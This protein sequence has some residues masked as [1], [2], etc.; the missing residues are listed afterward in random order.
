MHAC[1]LA[2]TLGIPRVLV[3][4]SPGVLSALG[5][6]IADVVKDYSHTVMLGPEALDWNQLEKVF[7]PLEEQGY[8]EMRREGFDDHSMIARRFLDLRY[9]GQSYEL[10]VP[11]DWEKG[12][13]S[14]ETL[15]HRFHEAHLQRYGHSDPRKPIELVNA[16]LKMIGRA[17]PVKLR[18]E[19]EVTDTISSTATLERREVFF[20]GQM[21]QTQVYLREGL[22]PGNELPGPAIVEQLDATTVI[23]PE[24]A[25]KV[26]AWGNLLLEKR[27]AP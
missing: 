18:F 15:I 2:T 9:I 5:V 25:S 16:R 21:C 8:F 7:Q 13:L 23:P 27:N 11:Y 4:I 1:E 12:D 19:E 22:R 17:D 10:M 3:P 14:V 20:D 26:D 24:W 6:A